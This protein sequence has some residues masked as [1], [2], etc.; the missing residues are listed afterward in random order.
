MYQVYLSLRNVCLVCHDIFS[1]G[2]SIFSSLTVMCHIQVM[3]TFL[4]MQF[5][6]VWVVYSLLLSL[7]LPC[8]T[9]L[10]PNNKYKHW[11]CLFSD[12]PI[13]INTCNMS[14]PSCILQTNSEELEVI[15]IKSYINMVDDN[16]SLAAFKHYWRIR[17]KPIL[18]D[19]Y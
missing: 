17:G 18:A 19:N 7:R 1:V 14:L 11:Y 15:A 16:L 10:I 6:P 4:I 5:L 3:S 13:N 9:L 2:S 8:W 12:R